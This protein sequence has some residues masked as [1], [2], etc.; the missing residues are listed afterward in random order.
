M[1]K[2]VLHISYRST[3]SGFEMGFGRIASILANVIFGELVNIYCLVPMFLV[4]GFMT[5][6]G[7]SALMLPNMAGRDIDR[8]IST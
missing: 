2:I 5:V 4:A 3:A 8:S 1:I 6:G 7:L